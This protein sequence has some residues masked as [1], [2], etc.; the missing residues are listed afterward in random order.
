[1]HTHSNNNGMHACMH[2]C[3]GHATPC[4]NQQHHVLHAYTHQLHGASQCTLTA[5]F[6]CMHN[7]R[8]SLYKPT[9]A[10]LACVCISTARRACML[11][12]CTGSMRAQQTTHTA[13]RAH[14]RHPH[15]VLAYEQTLCGLHTQS[16]NS[17]LFACTCMSTTRFTPG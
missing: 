12:N 1:M 11:S 8:N 2:A 6:A 9:T 16:N 7:T 17:S 14:V 5:R 3:T 4:I 13:A 10:R 15:N